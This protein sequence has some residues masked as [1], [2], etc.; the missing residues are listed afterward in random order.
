MGSPGHAGSQTWYRTC[1]DDRMRRQ[2]DEISA[3]VKATRNPAV[4][5]VGGFLNRGKTTN[6]ILCCEYIQKNFDQTTQVGIG[7]DGFIKAYQNTIA[8]SISNQSNAKCVIFDEPSEYSSS[9][10]SRKKIAEVNKILDTIKHHQVIIFI[11]G[12]S[13][14][15]LNQHLWKLGAVRG[16]I[17]I[18]RVDMG[19]CA[20]YTMH[21]ART[22]LRIV[23]EC[24][25][26]EKN[27]QIDQAIYFAYKKY[28]ARG[29]RGRFKAPIKKK[30][31]FIDDN[32]DKG[33]NEMQARAFKRAEE[34][35]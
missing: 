7:I 20:H 1:L 11:A 6:A 13:F 14:W 27:Y 35:D 31:Q 32:S 9:G 33:K 18:I 2:L 4:I 30:Q 34:F 5:I 16:L 3:D 19:K 17:H 15:E 23:G 28:V 10:G 8:M 22:T 12:P 24:R 25:R 29:I 26:A 21:D